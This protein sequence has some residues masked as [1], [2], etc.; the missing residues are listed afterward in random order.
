MSVILRPVD[1]K[2]WRGV[3][4][5]KLRDDQKHFV[6]SNVFSLAESKYGGDEDDGH[7]D[8]F[9]VAIYA[10]DV[11]VGFAMYAIN[12][13]GEK[14]QG[15]I[16]RLMIDVQFQGKGYGREAMK[17]LITIF[18]QDTKIKNVGISYEPENEV[19]RKLYASLGFVETGNIVDGEMVAM[20]EGH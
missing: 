6:S 17:L 9:P 8:L 15:F 13:N 4:D 10:D 18:T 11:L 12:Y 7:W 14:F 16:D 19:A 1:H 5:L 3:I 20:L 2:N